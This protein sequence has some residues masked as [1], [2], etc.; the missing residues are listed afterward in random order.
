MNDPNAAQPDTLTD[1]DLLGI[2]EGTLPADR[3]QAAR[4]AL[5]ASPALVTRIKQLKDDRAML[6]SDEHSIDPPSDCV[7]PAIRSVL[8]RGVWPVASATET[9]VSSADLPVAKITGS[10]VERASSGRRWLAMI[11]SGL[12]VAAAIGI[13][14]TLIVYGATN[15][16]TLNQTND[17]DLSGYKIISTDPSEL[18]A[19]AESAQAI[20]ENI[21]TLLFGDDPTQLDVPRLSPDRHWHRSELAGVTGFVSTAFAFDL[22]SDSRLTISVPRA[23][24]ASLD[25]N[26]DLTALV[27]WVPNQQ[28]T[29]TGRRAIYGL[30]GELSVDITRLAMVLDT[31]DAAAREVGSS[32][33]LSVETPVA[34]SPEEPISDRDVFWWTRPASEWS[35]SSAAFTIMPLDEDASSTVTDQQ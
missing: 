14:S 23:V 5:A 2:I 4:A 30:I 8:A 27:Q 9:P 33:V 6:Q 29:G 34:E 12:G 15:S 18:I 13:A 22:A 20:N 31:L 3:E 19:E 25:S 24:Y 26:P 7:Q 16:N 35:K 28:M 21:D 17:I 32:I 10:R 1:A 11:G